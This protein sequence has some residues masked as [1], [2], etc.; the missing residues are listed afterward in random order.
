MK[1]EDEVINV[2]GMADHTR[3]TLCMFMLAVLSFNPFGIVIDQLSNAETESALP[4]K[5]RILNF[6]GKVS[7]GEFFLAKGFFAYRLRFY[8]FSFQRRQIILGLGSVRPF[9]FGA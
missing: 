9:F 6:E 4:E 3:L 8:L 5:R 2:G 1:E 7:K